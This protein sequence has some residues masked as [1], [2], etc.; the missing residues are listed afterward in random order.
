MPSAAR[1]DLC[2]IGAGAAG[3]SVA[4]GAAQMGAR[5]V[6]VEKHLMG[7]DCLNT[8]C[9]PSKSLLAAARVAQEARTSGH[10]GVASHEPRID[11]RA[12]HDHV[13]G[14]IAQIAPHD[15][16]ER[17]EG[18][19]VRVIRAAARF[20]GPREVAAGD[21]CIRARRFVVATGSSADV[22]PIPGLDETPFLTNETVFGLTGCPGHLVVIGG[23]PIG[24]E[25]AQAHRRLGAAVTVLDAGRILPRDDPE[26]VEVV[27]RRLLA[28]G[29]V[30]REGVQVRAVARRDGGVAVAVAAGEG[31]HTIA[32]SH[33]LVATGRRA[34]VDGLGLEAAGIEYSGRGIAVDARLRTTNKRVFAAGDVAGGRFTHEAGYHAGIV[35]RNALFRWPA[36]AGAAMP[37]VTYTDPELAH[38]GLRADEA[39]A[40]GGASVARFG[41]AGLDRARAERDTEGFAKVVV[42]RRGRVL[43]A[44]VVGRGAGELILPWVL[45]VDR[46]IGIGAMAG[47]VAP[48]P[49]LAEVSKRAAGAY[50]A[51]KLFGAGTRRVVRLLRHLG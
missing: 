49:T 27:R 33:L 23:G 31:E 47:V 14:V 20:T 42:G 44:T 13:H 2:V 51:P 8:G 15:S 38:V 46:G 5:V 19:G 12:V 10:F 21:A 3:L 18:L 26:A 25:L 34:N 17:F 41:F 6:L 39:D 37:W 48:Y 43:G 28:E 30:L 45:A 7:G 4:A 36:K 11:F 24:L 1:A 22:P 16:V 40:R 9:V 29:V 50:Y 32:G 35:L